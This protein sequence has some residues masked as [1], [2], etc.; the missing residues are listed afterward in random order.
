M[1]LTNRVL[2]AAEAEAAGI[3]TTVVPDDALDAELEALADRLRAG[4][5]GAF[6]S[7]KRLLQ[8]SATAS[9]GEQLEAEARAIAANAGRPDGREGVAAFLARRPPVFDGA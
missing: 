8:A 6:A 1:L 5:T 4:A 9:L 7:V 2:S 3:V